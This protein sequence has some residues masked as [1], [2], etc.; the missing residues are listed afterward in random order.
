MIDDRGRDKTMFVT[1]KGQWRFKVLSFRLCNALS[2]FAYIMKLVLS[3][4]TYDISN[5]SRSHPGLFTNF[6]RHCDYQAAIFDWPEHYML[7]LKPTKYHLFQRKV[8]F[9][10]HVATANK[11]VGGPN[12]QQV[13][14]Y[15]RA[16]IQNFAHV[17]SMLQ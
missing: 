13:S 15:Y 11:R 10:G 14:S 9:L 1:R 16:F 4:L 17:A 8:A 7:K 3:G 12:I 2:Q 5:L 6:R